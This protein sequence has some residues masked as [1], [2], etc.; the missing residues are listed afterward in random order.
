MDAPTTHKLNVA[1]LSKQL[2]KEA[3]YNTFFAKLA[4]FMNYTE[5][6]G[7]K[8][9]NPAPNSVIQ[10][11]RDFITQG[12]DN[13]I[14]PLMLP[15]I[16]EG[17]FGDAPLIGTGEELRLKYLRL[18]I[19]QHRKAVTKL[20]GRAANQRVKIYNI[21]EQ[22]KPE[23]VKWWSKTENQSIFQTIYEGLSPNLS[24]GTNDQG[25]GIKVR[26]HPNWYYW[27]NAG[28][29]FVSLGPASFTKTP[30]NMTAL[31][32]ANVGAMSSR[33]LLNL[34]EL[35]TTDLLIEPVVYEGSPFWLMLVH[36]RTFKNLK[37]DTLVKADQNAAFNGKLS[38][39]PAINGKQ[40]LYYEGFC[41][42]PDPIGVR[43][44]PSGANNPMQQLAGNGWLYPSP[45]ANAICNS[46]ILGRNAIGKGLADPLNFT[47]EEF[48]H[49]NTIELGTNQSYGYNRAEFF[50]S[51]DEAAVFE[52]DGAVKSA[53]TINYEATNQSSMIISTED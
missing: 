24:N 12:R 41:I 25:L 11:M 38:Q 42:I 21:M 33:T 9:Y 13:M 48:D 35:I 46:I 47:E 7:I 45:T 1:I 20:S 16:E 31:T 32:T 29:A 44:L 34:V 2:A 5:T 17:V 36:P 51:A 50:A 19:N 23:L 10:V 52:R 53:L 14:M 22:A 49:K 4:G 26:F 43:L 6:N 39:H 15:L 30:A 18:Y 27:N 37:Q 28:T 8:Q 40:M 3:W